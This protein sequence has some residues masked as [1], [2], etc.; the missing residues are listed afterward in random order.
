MKEVLIVA[1]WDGEEDVKTRTVLVTMKSKELK[2]NGKKPNKV[3]VPESLIDI[4]LIRKIKNMCTYNCK[5]VK[6][7]GK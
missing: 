2:L 3:I 7:V 4:G 6:A 1:I 5:I